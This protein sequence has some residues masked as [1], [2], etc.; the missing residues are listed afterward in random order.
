MFTS[1]I[2]Y[3]LR[4]AKVARF[5]IDSSFLCTL[6]ISRYAIV[7]ENNLVKWSTLNQVHVPR[8]FFSKDHVAS[9][10]EDDALTCRVIV[11]PYASDHFSNSQ[12]HVN[13][14]LARYPGEHNPATVAAAMAILRP[15]PTW[16]GLSFATPFGGVAA[17]S[18]SPLSLPSSPS[19]LPVSPKLF[20]KATRDEKRRDERE[21]RGHTVADLILCDSYRIILLYWSNVEKGNTPIAVAVIN[22]LQNTLKRL[23]EYSTI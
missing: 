6:Y 13:M 16:P 5:I 4:P 18:T 20:S 23:L 22:T 8:V 17:T 10:V 7:I 9:R 3:H 1:H 14:R 12:K 21:G 19:D 2:K 15:R 11:F